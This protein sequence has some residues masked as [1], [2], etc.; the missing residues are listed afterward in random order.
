[1]LTNSNRNIH[2]VW[3]T[4]IWWLSASVCA[5]GIKINRL[6]FKLFLFTDNWHHPKLSS[7]E[8]ICG[9]HEWITL[10]NSEL[11]TFSESAH[12]NDLFMIQTDPVLKFNSLT[13]L[14]TANNSSLKNIGI[15]GSMK[16]NSI[17]TKGSLGWK[18]SSLDFSN[19]LCTKKKWFF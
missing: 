5:A 3:H 2:Q 12:L 9:I 14:S 18:K 13:Q 10:L 17:C 16:N 8:Q 7:K 1:M 4:V 19:G 15:D 6:E 11:G